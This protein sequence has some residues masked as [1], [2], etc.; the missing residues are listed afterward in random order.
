MRLIVMVTCLMLS[1]CAAEPDRLY[2]KASKNWGPERVEILGSVTTYDLVK[3]SRCRSMQV[4][5]CD[6]AESPD[7]C[8]CVDVNRAED[9][10]RR[11][12]GQS[13]SRHFHN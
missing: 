7:T 9:R 2:G 11:M 8:R 13:R 12:T 4:L 10:V 5:W 3:E 1:A 6:V